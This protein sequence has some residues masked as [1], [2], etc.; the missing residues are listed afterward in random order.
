MDVGLGLSVTCS[1][2]VITIRL[3][4]CFSG[5]WSRTESMVDQW[6]GLQKV[7]ILVLVDVG[8]GRLPLGVRG[9]G[10]GLVLILVLVDVGLGRSEDAGADGSAKS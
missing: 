10:R 5:C 1:G 6:S 7:L 2:S 8:L 9:M 3:N 4:P